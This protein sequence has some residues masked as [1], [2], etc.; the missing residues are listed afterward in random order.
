MLTNKLLEYE[1]TQLRKARRGGPTATASYE[2]K[3]T[4]IT[5]RLIEPPPPQSPSKHENLETLWSML[6]SHQPLKT[7]LVKTIEDQANKKM[8]LNVSVSRTTSFPT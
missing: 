1:K 3:I 5:L 4:E 7:K 2:D 8:V 6:D